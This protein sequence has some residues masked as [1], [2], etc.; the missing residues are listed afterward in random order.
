LRWARF[1]LAEEE[2][3]RVGDLGLS[4][5]LRRLALHAAQRV[6]LGNE[7]SSHHDPSVGLPGVV[8]QFARQCA[9]GEFH[10]IQI[11]VA[12]GRVEFAKVAVRSFELLDLRFF[13][14]TR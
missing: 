10:D 6:A 4:C 3:R 2:L 13:C 1:D 7:Y 11:H 5:G 8:E 9:F 12:K 14:V